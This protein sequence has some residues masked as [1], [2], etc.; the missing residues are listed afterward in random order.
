[1]QAT[2]SDIVTKDV[3]F[4]HQRQVLAVCPGL[5]DDLDPDNA[6]V[7]VLAYAHHA[8]AEQLRPVTVVTE[9]VGPLPVRM[10]VTEACASL[11]FDCIST[12]DFLAGI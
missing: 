4:A 3:P 6:H 12:A 9:D 8:S 11:G 7:G 10:S 1:M 5:W 2:A